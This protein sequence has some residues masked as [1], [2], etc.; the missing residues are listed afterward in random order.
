MPTTIQPK[1]VA[2]VAPSNGV[3][4]SLGP[5]LHFQKHKYKSHGEKVSRIPNVTVTVDPVP[6]EPRGSSSTAG[7]QVALKVEYGFIICPQDPLD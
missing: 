6:K 4:D 5:A 7:E 3:V 1:P 2:K